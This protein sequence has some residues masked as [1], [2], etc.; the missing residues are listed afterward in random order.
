[1]ALFGRSKTE[2]V[3]LFYEN[4]NER[5]FK[6]ESNNTVVRIDDYFIR[7]ARGKDIGTL[8]IHGLDGE[9]SILLNDI[10]SYQ[11]KAPGKTTGYLQFSYPGSIEPKGGV[12]DAVQDEN[13]ITFNKNE[14]EQ[15]LE[16]KKSIEYALIKRTNKN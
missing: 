13:T 4:E 11:L 2:E 10:T 15:A 3:N 5:I 14:A 12:F 1:M 16:L 8:L 9:K 6:F 7:I